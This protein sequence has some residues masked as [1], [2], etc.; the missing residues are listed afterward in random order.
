MIALK[1]NSLFAKPSRT[2]N[3]L[4]T[5]VC[6][7]ILQNQDVVSIALPINLEWFGNRVVTQTKLSLTEVTLKQVTAAEI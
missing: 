6:N 3:C 2:L 5:R 7:N 1:S 4:K